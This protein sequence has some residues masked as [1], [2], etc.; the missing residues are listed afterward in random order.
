MSEAEALV[1]IEERAIDFYGDSITALLVPGDPQPDIYIVLRPLC[2]YLG[3]SWSGQYERIKRDPVL[4]EALQFVRV[5]RTN[6]AG[7]DPTLLCLPLEFLPGWLFGISVARVRPELQDKITRYRRECFRVLWRAFQADALSALRASEASA[8]T[9]AGEPTALAQIHA[10][11]LAVVQMA[12]QQMMAEQRLTAHDGRLD[13]AAS[14]IKAVQSRLDALEDRLAPDA[15][16]S[17]AQAAELTMLVRAVAQALTAQDPAKNQYQGVFA[18]LY[19]RFQVTSY[20]LVRQEQFPDVVAF[21][22]HWQATIP[23]T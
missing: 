8:R 7:G 3:L 11:G 5:T 17:E 16:I 4:D 2:D 20:K 23:T 19:R 13:R 10:L 21:L 9:P 22:Q 14:V 12:E 6:S 18:E 1:P 15:F